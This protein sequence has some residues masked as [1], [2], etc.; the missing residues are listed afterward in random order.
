MSKS[1]KLRCV[2]AAFPIKYSNIVQYIVRS[3][4]GLYSAHKVELLFTD[5]PLP[6]PRSAKPECRSPHARALARVKRLVASSH[7]RALARVKRLVGSSSCIAVFV[8]DATLSFAAFFALCLGEADFSSLILELLA[9]LFWMEPGMRR[10][11]SIGSQE[12]LNRLA[13]GELS[14]ICGKGSPKPSFI[15]FTKPFSWSFSPSPL[16]CTFGT[17]RRSRNRFTV[18]ASS[19]LQESIEL[20]PGLDVLPLTKYFNII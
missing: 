16:F 14:L 5:L 11:E 20:P 7:S 1:M 8:T 9:L 10:L 15:K 13:L 19:S 2:Y 3:R 6:L 12:V 17:S 4:T 18:R